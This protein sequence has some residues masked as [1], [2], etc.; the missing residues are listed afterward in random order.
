MA[1]CKICN[2]KIMEL[3]LGKFK[4]TILKKPGSKKQYA[5]CFE[6]Q[7]KLKSKE[8]MLEKVK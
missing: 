4:G 6:C 8:E 7:K 1:K 2:N 5:V 3:F